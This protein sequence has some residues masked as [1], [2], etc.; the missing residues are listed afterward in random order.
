MDEIFGGGAVSKRDHLVLPGSDQSKKRWNRKHDTILFYSK[1][2]AFTFNYEP[3]GSPTPSSNI[4]KYR[5]QDEKGAY[6]LMGRGIVN[7]PAAL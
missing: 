5:H 4:R 2:E 7:S 6:R 1:G 3:C